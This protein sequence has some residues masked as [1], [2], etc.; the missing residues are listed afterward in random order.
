MKNNWAIALIATVALSLQVILFQ[1]QQI[2]SLRQELRI[3]QKAKEIEQ[4][5]SQELMFQLSQAKMENSSL[6]TKYFVAGIVEAVTKPEHYSE[7]WHAGYDR[8]AATQ[9]YAQYT[10]IKE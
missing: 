7:I 8:G 1:Y 2:S 10:K 5:Q 4:D 6:S 3:T 9:E